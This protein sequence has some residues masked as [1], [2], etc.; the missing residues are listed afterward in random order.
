MIFIETSSFTKHVSEYL[1][2]DEF[3]AL[4]VYLLEHPDS[5]RVIRGT[6]GVRK[7][8]W[9][10]SGRGKSGGVR[11]IY[12]WRF[13]EDEIWLL[14]IY[15]KSEKDTIPAHILRRIAEEIGRD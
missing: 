3:L 8:R 2:D 1:S 9:A 10:G 15:R 12:L 14:A 6:G 13:S 5:G 11:V 4:Q 7:V